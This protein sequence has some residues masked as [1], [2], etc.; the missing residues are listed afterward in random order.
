[1]ATAERADARRNRARLIDTTTILFAERGIDVSVREIAREARV[2]IAT[3]YRHFPTRDD[4]VDAVLQVAFDELTA[5]STRALAAE[6]AWAG[7][8]GLVEETLS[9]HARNRGLRDA[10]D[11]QRGRERAAAMRADIWPVFAELVERAQTQGALRRDFTPQDVWL[12]FWAADAVIE[13]TAAVAPDV[14]RR[15]LAVMLDGIRAPAESPLP[16][17]ALSRAQLGQVGHRPRATSPRPTAGS[18]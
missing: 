5:A 14:W 1:V 15:Q 18:D 2:G 16:H 3:L 8:T 6:D 9:L 4:L 10:F 12:L 11:T 17:P 7:L 13:R